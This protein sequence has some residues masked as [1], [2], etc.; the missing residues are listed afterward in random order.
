MV[1]LMELRKAHIRNKTR[2]GQ[3]RVS[4]HVKGAPGTSP[5]KNVRV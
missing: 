1:T 5:V 3:P 4:K 2:G